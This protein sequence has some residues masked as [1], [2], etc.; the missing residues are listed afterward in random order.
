MIG[1]SVGLFAAALCVAASRSE[2]ARFSG[3]AKRVDG[4]RKVFQRAP[5]AF[6]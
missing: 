6:R 4:Q 2:D 1:A 5:H 3:Q